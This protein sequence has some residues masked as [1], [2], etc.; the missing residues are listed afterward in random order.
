MRA[1]ASYSL[2]KDDKALINSSA[3]FISV[4]PPVYIGVRRHL[5]VAAELFLSFVRTEKKATS[6][7]LHVTER[8]GCLDN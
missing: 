8:K 3:A 1:A 5:K 2:K 4:S 7:A 6:E